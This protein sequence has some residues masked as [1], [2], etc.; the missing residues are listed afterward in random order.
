MFWQQIDSFI[1]A[2][3]P[4]APT[5]Q[6]HHLV[7]VGDRL[8]APADAPHWRPL[9]QEEW[10]WLD[11]DRKATHYL[12]T[13]DGHPCYAEDVEGPAPSGYNSIDLRSLLGLANADL[14]AAAGRGW[15][16]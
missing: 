2:N 6:S 9:H 15:R 11:V 4:L 12:G 14:F 7:F 13:L 16:A 3:S 8:L 10:R 1:P 5:D